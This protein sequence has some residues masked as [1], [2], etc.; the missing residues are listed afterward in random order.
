MHI[1]TI[2]WRCRVLIFVAVVG[3]AIGAIPSP[4][5]LES[6]QAAPAFT[7]VTID[8][9]TPQSFA[10][11]GS[12]VASVGDVDGDGVPDLLVGARF[13]N[14]GATTSQ[15]QAFLFSG[16][17]GLLIRTLD[18]PT[19]QAGAQFGFAVAGVGD[20]DGDG[21]P[22]LLVA[23]PTQT[24]GANASQGQVFVFSGATGVL[25]RTLN[26]PTRQAGAQFGFAVAGVGDVDGDGVADILIGASNQTVGANAQGEAFVFSGATGRLLQTLDDPT[27]QAG[28]Q[29]GSSVA[30]LGD[31]DGDGVADLLIGA[32]FQTVSANI[33]QGQAFVFSGATGFLIHTLDDPTPQAGA[34]FGFA[35]TGLGDVD[36][37]GVTDLLV[38]APFQAVGPN[39]NQG[40]AFV[41][42]GKTGLLLRALDDPTPQAGAEFGFS[43]AGLGDVNA[44]KVPDL[45]IGASNQTVSPNTGQGQ[46]F[47]FSGKSGLLL[48]TVD[49]PTPQAGAQFGFAVASAGDVNKDKVPD[50]LIGA[51]NQNVGANGAQGQ[52]FLF[53]SPRSSQFAV[54]DPQVTITLRPG[55]ND[56]QFTLTARAVLANI[57]NGIHP[58][59]ERVTIGIGP[60]TTT[61]P[62]GS[63]VATASGFRF[64]GRV[65]GVPLKVVIT[66]LGATRFR[67]TAK[68]SRVDLSHAVNPV[69]ARVRIGNDGRTKKVNAVFTRL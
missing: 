59:T 6:A 15:G 67:V 41:F 52:A 22:D 44:D 38:G 56:D 13:Q 68:G 34:E 33:N 55:L 46:A 9:P 61:I 26:D 58:L 11:F 24:V 27:P 37:D 51:S 57:S 40:R 50:L 60:F 18:D 1:E 69:P 3:L 36:R 8:D 42:S 17:T 25:L 10:S 20:V 49:D 53:V 31:V 43:V 7:P 29:F 14:V 21:V 66:R 28:A 5:I 64:T 30:G 54:F 63:F 23:A 39:A 2:S 45:L 47:V 4:F 32:R 16:K 19:S 65:A 62:A 12:A 48:V 35:V